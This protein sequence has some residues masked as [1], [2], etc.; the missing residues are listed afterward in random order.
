MAAQ[1]PP[2]NLP[3]RGP[4]DGTWESI[5]KDRTRV[6]ANRDQGA[7]LPEPGSFTLY[8]EFELRLPI[9][10]VSKN[11]IAPSWACWNP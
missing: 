11:G 6:D 10:M 5:N 3:I 9:N 7:N 2:G 4:P 1:V 8:T